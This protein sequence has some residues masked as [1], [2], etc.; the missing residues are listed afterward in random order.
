MD[1]FVN[2]REKVLV[3]NGKRG[4]LKVP[5]LGRNDARNLAKISYATK[6][7]KTELAEVKSCI[8]VSCQNNWHKSMVNLGYN[9]VLEAM[10][11]DSLLLLWK[12]ET[13]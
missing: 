10:L 8:I 4:E 1:V 7:Y 3:W 13:L 2:E 5:W 9:F 12:I 6:S 11:L